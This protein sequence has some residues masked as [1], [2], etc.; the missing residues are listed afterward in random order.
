[1]K[2]YIDRVTILFVYIVTLFIVIAH[3]IAT[4]TKID[5]SRKDLHLSDSINNRIKKINSIKKKN[6]SKITF[7]KKKKIVNRNNSIDDILIQ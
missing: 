5:H 2:K 6:Y 3:S 4:N 7:V 1:M